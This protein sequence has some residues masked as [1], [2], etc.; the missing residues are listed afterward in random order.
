MTLIAPTLQAF[1]TDRLAKQLNASPRTIASYRDTLS[2]LLRF[3][4]DTT[5]TAPSA[6]QWD[7]LDEPVI[8]AFLQHLETDRHNSPRTRNLRLTAIRSLFSYAA[9]RHPEHAAVIG[10]VLSIPPKRFQRRSVTFLTA[11]ESQALID[12]PPPGRWEGRRDRA[13]LTLTIQAGLRVSE[14]I[15]VN[16]GD[17]TLGTV[18][19]CMW[20][21]R[22]ANT[23]PFRSPTRLKQ[24]SP[25]GSPNDEAHQQTRCSRPAQPA[26]SVATPSSDA[27]RPTSRPP[28]HDAHRSQANGSTP[29]S[30]G[31]AARWRCCE[32]GSTPP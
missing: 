21:A 23:A 22:D 31:T 9:I 28:P 12:A 4:K 24:S 26:G 15:A 11:K 16:C 2:L 20:K 6:L 30:S 10:R 29:M 19:A 17:V 14:L 8:A 3:V 13:M 32:P 5:G 27:S 7:D 1:F 25:S 18:G